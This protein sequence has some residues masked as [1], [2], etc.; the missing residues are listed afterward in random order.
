MLPKIHRL[1]KKDIDI[2]FKQGAGFRTPLVFIR[3]RH[4]QLPLARFCIL[5]TKAAKLSSVE[6]NALRRQAYTLI[7]GQLE[8]F[9]KGLDYGIMISPTLANTPSAKRR[10]HL[11]KALEVIL[12]PNHSS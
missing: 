1:S 12:K 2:L 7:R 10:E 8:N 4:T 3:K 5:F 9:E 6:R 11:Q